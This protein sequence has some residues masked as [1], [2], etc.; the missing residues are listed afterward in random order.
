MLV[1]RM[2]TVTAH[3][4]SFLPA[5]GSRT[6]KLLITSTMQRVCTLEVC[7]VEWYACIQGGPVQLEGVDAISVGRLL[8]QVPRQVDDEDGIER[9]FLHR[10]Q[11]CIQLTAIAQCLVGISQMTDLTSPSAAGFQQRP[12]PPCRTLTQMPQPMHSSSEMYAT[13][14]AGVTSIQS[15]PACMHELAKLRCNS[16]RHWDGS[17][18]MQIELH[19]FMRYACIVS[20]DDCD[21][22]IAHRS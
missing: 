12:N 11:R 7:C 10:Y 13:F 9:A 17:N 20:S 3:L 4:S 8:R 22:S 21:V 1:L 15:L 2:F 14:E 19:Q 16:G 6:D 18:D 5:A